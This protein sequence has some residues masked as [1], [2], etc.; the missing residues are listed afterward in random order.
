MRREC[1]PPF[2]GPWLPNTM[3]T[4]HRTAMTRCVLF[5]VSASLQACCR[6]MP[7]TSLAAAPSARP[8]C[9]E[10]ADQST[11]AHVCNVSRP[12]A[13]AAAHSRDCAAYAGPCQL[14][15]YHLLCTRLNAVLLLNF[16]SCSHTLAYLPLSS[17]LYPS[18]PQ[19]LTPLDPSTSH[20]LTPPQFHLLVELAGAAPL[21]EYEPDV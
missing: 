13:A 4:R 3:H 2:A 9:G 14:F 5:W 7:L 11:E 12:L 19:P 20:P 6:D 21:A 16:F 18:T 8:R 15:L 17:T 10:H 1:V